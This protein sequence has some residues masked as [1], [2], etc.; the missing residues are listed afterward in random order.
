M[1]AILPD[2]GVLWWQGAK[3]VVSP[4]YSGVSGTVDCRPRL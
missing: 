3:P 1:V 4:T 2:L